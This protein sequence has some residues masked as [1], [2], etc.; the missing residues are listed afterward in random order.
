[1]AKVEKQVADIAKWLQGFAPEKQGQLVKQIQLK[2]VT[3]TPADDLLQAP[4]SKLGD[5]LEMEIE[6]PPE[7]VSP[8]VIV[9]GEIHALAARAGKGKTTFL[10]NCMMRWAAGMP[11]FDDLPDLLVP[12]VENGVR[13]LV[14][15][16]EGSAGYF[17]DRVKDLL[18]HGGYTDDQKALIKEN[19]L[20][21]GD[22][23]YSGVKVDDSSKLELLRRG[24]KKWEPD[25][26]FLDPFRSI[27]TGN[28]NDG[29]EMNEAIDNLMQL[30]HDFEC[31][32]FVN[33]HENKGKDNMDAMDSLRG[34]TVFEGAL[35]TVMRWQHV[36]GGAQSEL[37]MTKMRYKPKTGAPAPIRMAFNFDTWTYTHIGES[38][39]DRQ[40]LDM[41]NANDDQYFTV[42][43]VADELE[44]AERKV[45]ERL[46]TLVEDGRV[47]KARAASGSGYS[48]RIKTDDADTASA[49][50]GGL[51]ID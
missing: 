15:E 2:A 18:E 26:V 38:V 50:H 40:I 31:A 3:E 30:C 1:M 25:L 47:Q 6:T 43:E 13:C 5:Y 28:E 34:S 20:I 29:S 41:L 48:F 46:K 4:I 35:A 24:V 32:V 12:G 21:W 11:L 45:R 44:E 23:S 7:I 19:M 8:G 49:G 16:N 22:G 14:I 10:M 33:H 27:W 17:Q 39:L 51:E 9:R 36:H 37:S 42:G